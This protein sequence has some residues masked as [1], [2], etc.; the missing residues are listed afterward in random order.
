MRARGLLPPAPSAPFLIATGPRPFLASLFCPLPHRQ[1]LDAVLRLDAT[2]ANALRLRA[3]ISA[4]V[5]Q[6]QTVR[7]I[8]AEE[9]DPLAVFGLDEGA[10]AQ[11]IKREFHRLSLLVHPVRC[12]RGLGGYAPW[13]ASPRARRYSGRA[14]H[15]EAAAPRRFSP[16]AP[17]TSATTRRRRPLSAG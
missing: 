7:R 16:R 8:A 12:L 3:E 13:G 17:R 5:A 15:A 14:L 4:E 10:S 6:K 11:D 2:H 1:F 9:G